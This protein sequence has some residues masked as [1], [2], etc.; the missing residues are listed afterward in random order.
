M[1]WNQ[2]R[3]TIHAIGR[4]DRAYCTRVP[5]LASDLLV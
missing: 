4:A 5:D 1:A 3:N 2:N